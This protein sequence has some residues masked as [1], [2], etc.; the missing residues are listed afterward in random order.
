MSNNTEIY[1]GSRVINTSFNEVLV[2]TQTFLSERHSDL[3][4]E[5]PDEENRKHLY[6]YIRQFLIDNN[7]RCEGMDLDA[8]V[9]ALYRE[10]VEFSILTEFLERND[11]EEININGWNDIE[12]IY[13]TGEMK[14]LD[15]TFESPR[16]SIN[17]LRRMLHM[18]GNIIDDAMPAVLGHLGKNIRIAALKTPIV[19][20][21]RGISC[22]IRIVNPT[23]LQK[24]DLL[25]SDTAT[26]E[27][28]DFLTLCLQYSVSICVSGETSSGKT[29]LAGYLLNTMPDDMRIYTIESGS[30]E[31]NPIKYDENGRIKNRIVSTLARPSEDS[32]K[33]IT[34]EKLV[35]FSLRFDPDLIVV[36]EMRESEAYIAQEAARTGHGVLTTIHANSAEAT[37]GRMVTLCKRVS[38]LD[39]EDLME[40]VVEAFPI[41]V[42]ARKLRDKSRKIMDILECEN[43]PDGRRE[44]HHLF[45]YVVKRNRKVDGQVIID[46]EFKT[47]NQMS[48]KLFNTLRDNGMSDEE[49]IGIFGRLPDYVLIEEGGDE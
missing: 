4:M 49:Y 8:L 1:F 18:S 24:E 27:M 17:V 38:D 15:R 44:Y 43:K 16:H 5:K 2:K 39:K 48:H 20:E 11:I 21:E 9:Q 23:N 30:R 31:L 6:R 12:V 32:N 29:T 3:L 7:L 41:V 26:E 45:R 13:N 14:K 22:S 47:V 42:F 25:R 34:Q 19:D 10:M 46:G 35:D 28:L 33:N 36:G 40:N 37:Y